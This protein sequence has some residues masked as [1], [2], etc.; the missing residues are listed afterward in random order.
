MK[1]LVMA[2]FRGRS[3]VKPFFD[4]DGSLFFKKLNNWNVL[5]YNGRFYWNPS[6][7]EVGWFDAETP[8][9]V[10]PLPESEICYLTDDMPIDIPGLML[11][12]RQLVGEEQW[13][14]F[15]EKQG[16]P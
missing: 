15:V 12:L 11:Y 8:P 6:S 13:S 16:I 4:K 10:K 1:H 9:A 3:A 2:A 5:R 7:E 14:R